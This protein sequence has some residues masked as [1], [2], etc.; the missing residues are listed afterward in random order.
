MREQPPPEEPVVEPEAPAED[1]ETPPDTTAADAEPE[2]EDGA[3][4]AE[5]GP[6]VSVEPYAGIGIATRSVRMPAP[7]GVLRVAPG[8]TPAAEVGLRVVAWPSADFGLVVNVVYQSAL[9]FSV[10]ERPPL[11][12][13]KEVGARSE[14]V[15]LEVAPRWRFAGGKLNLA[16]P[17]G[18][19]VRTLWAEVHLSQTPSFSLVGPHVRAELRLSLSDVLSLRVA[20]ELHYIMMVDDDL[21]NAGVSSQGVALGGDGS[22]EAQISQTWSFGINYRESHALL[23]AARGSVSFQDVERYLTLRA[24]GSF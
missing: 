1:A 14:R 13:P 7:A 18:A 9:G 6:S 12:L 20:P 11:A 4:A 22:I 3:Q 23:S 24:V 8:V 17:V 15:A 21:V 16:I 10:I 5:S 19:T 2:P